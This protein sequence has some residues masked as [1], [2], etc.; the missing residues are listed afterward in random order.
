[1]GASSV[2]AQHRA[3][4]SAPCNCKYINTL[5][6][7]RL[8]G[9][10]AAAQAT[11]SGYYQYVMAAAQLHQYQVWPWTRRVGCRQT[12]ISSATPAVALALLLFPGPRLVHHPSSHAP[13]DSVRTMSSPSHQRLEQ[14]AAHLKALPPVPHVAADSLSPSVPP[15]QRVP[16]PRADSRRR[17]AGKVA[18]VT[19]T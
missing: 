12:N 8:P 10:V 1:M 17:L 11:A 19:G 9:R 7:R 6:T 13:G 16:R 3:G 4:I 18:I 15:P 14:V 2:S 5:A